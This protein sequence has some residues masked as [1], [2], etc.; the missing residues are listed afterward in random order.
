M[1]RKLMSVCSILAFCF[2]CIVLSKE[3]KDFSNI[4]VLHLS[5][6]KGCLHDIEQVCQELGIHV[7]SWYIFDASYPKMWFDGYSTGGRLYNIGYER[8]KRI[9]EKHKD[10]FNQFDVIFTSDTAPLARIFL[11]KG[12]EKPLI[13]WV[14][15]RFDYRNVRCMDCDFPDKQF[16][17][18]IREA[19]QKENVKIIPYTDYEYVYARRMGIDLGTRTIKPL[20][21]EE[22]EVGP[23]FKSAI[24]ETIKKEETIFIYPR[25]LE[26]QFYY[27]KNSCS[28]VGIKTYFGVYNG[29]ED[30]KGFKGVIYFPYQVSNLALFENFQRG[31]VHFVPSEKFIKYQRAKE[32]PIR[33][34]GWCSF[35]HC[36]WYK[37]ENR[38]YLVY[39]DSWDDLKDKIEHTDYETLRKKIKTI[40]RKHRSTMI[41]RWRYI[42]NEVVNFL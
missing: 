6:H 12:W 26:H 34:C 41:S 25:L 2:F 31:V 37:K 3:Y 32:K 16:Y 39:F 20:G 10:Y 36:E 29:P 21:T 42:F 14:C 27:I 11:Q 28:G 35:D 13:I 19:T 22:K 5:F 15:N 23:N 17:D 24:P 30:L 4:K 1:R 7:T 38:D 8:A 9:W 33:W 40:G 18:L